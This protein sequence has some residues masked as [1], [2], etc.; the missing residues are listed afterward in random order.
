MPQ[1][2]K[3]RAWPGT[4]SAGEQ[5]AGAAGQTP[6]RAVLHQFHNLLQSK[7]V[8]VDPPQPRDI[9]ITLSNAS[10]ATD[11]NDPKAVIPRRCI[12][13]CSPFEATP[14]Y[15]RTLRLRSRSAKSVCRAMRWIG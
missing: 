3:A 12:V 4:L 15:S 1:H 11:A 8:L 7:F 10:R 13:L 2:L 5:E 9:S 6:P 14:I